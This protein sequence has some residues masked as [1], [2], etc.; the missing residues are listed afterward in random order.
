MFVRFTQKN[1]TEIAVNADAVQVIQPI[2]EGTRL[3]FRLD[4]AVEVGEYFG[5]V[6][7]RLQ[8]ALA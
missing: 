7:E 8:D 6:L 1:G 5:D 2:A 3:V 4:D